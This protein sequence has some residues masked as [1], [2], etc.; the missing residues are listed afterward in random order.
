MARSAMVR[1][2]GGHEVS[3]RPDG[4][5]KYG[6]TLAHCSADGKDLGAAMV[7]QGMAVSSGGYFGEQLSARAARR[8]LWAGDFELPRSFRDD[9]K[10]Q[11]WPAPLDWLRNLF[12]QWAG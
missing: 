9:E 3:C 5:D 6:R 11:G 8:G 1:L 7:E 2:V 12:Q 10:H 4:R